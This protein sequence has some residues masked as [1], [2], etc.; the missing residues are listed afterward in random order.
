MTA[1]GA[2]ALGGMLAGK[3]KL[4]GKVLPHKLHLALKTGKADD[5][6]NTVALASM[7]TGVASG[8]NWSKKLRRDADPEAAAAAQTKA[9]NLAKAMS[10]DV[11]KGIIPS[12]VAR[13]ASTGALTMRR[14]GYRR[15]GKMLRPRKVV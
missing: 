10:G 15:A 1:V 6:R 3:T 4:A 11:T 5:A 12:A 13:T 14:A 9:A 2:T 7:L 8:V